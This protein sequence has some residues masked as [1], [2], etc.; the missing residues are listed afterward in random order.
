MENDPPMTRIPVAALSL[1]LA[2]SLAQGWLPAAFSADDPPAIDLFAA[3]DLS[4]WVEDQHDFFKRDH[5]GVKTWSIANGVIAADGSHGNAGFLRYEKTLCDFALTLEYRMSKGCNSGVCIR[6]R[7]PYTTIKPNTLPSHTGYEVQILDDAG[8]PTTV[9]STGALYN[10][11]PAKVNAAKAA[12][13][14]NSLA[15]ECRGPHLRVTLNGKLLHDVDQREVAEI[16][17]RPRCGYLS[18]QN[19]TNDVEF[20]NVR[21]REFK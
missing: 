20:R 8:K 10:S 12:G 3:G 18:L 15:I 11:V 13:E 4:G 2:L 19:H 21:L 17:D 9:H 7:V 1:L 5:P 16:K 14:W 6:A